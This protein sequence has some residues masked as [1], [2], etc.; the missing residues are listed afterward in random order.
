MMTRFGP[1]EQWEPLFDINS[2]PVASIEAIEYY[3]TA[4]ETPM[5]YATLNS[6][7]GVL[8]IHSLRYHSKDTASASPKPPAHDRS[9]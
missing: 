1:V 2:I 6:E 4:A 8:V 9:P 7:C 3:A 5:K